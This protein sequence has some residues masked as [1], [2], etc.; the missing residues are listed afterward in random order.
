M[1]DLIPFEDEPFIGLPGDIDF[2]E[3]G[4]RDP[5]AP[6]LKFRNADFALARQLAGRG[7]TAGLGQGAGL[8][9]ALHGSMQDEAATQALQQQRAGLGF[10]G[11]L[12]GL[13]LR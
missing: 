13:P 5:T 12:G 8:Q 7:A 3:P 1:K 2:R 11:Y 6:K 9:S 4:Q 10:F